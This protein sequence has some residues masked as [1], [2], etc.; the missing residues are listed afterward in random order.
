MIIVFVDWSKDEETARKSRKLVDLL[1]EMAVG[2]DHMFKFFW[3][4]DEK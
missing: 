1:S 3:T 4:D 2:I